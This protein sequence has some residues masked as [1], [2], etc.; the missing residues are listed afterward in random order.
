[1]RNRTVTVL[2]ATVLGLVA[3]SVLAADPSVIA[4][5]NLSSAGAAKVLAAA[6]L[7]ANRHGWA[8]SI[9]IVDAAGHLLAFQRTDGAPMGT[10]DVARRKAESSIKFKAPTEFLQKMV[11]QGGPAML[12]L[13]DYVAVVGGYPISVNG[14][15]VG[16]IGVSGGMA[17]EDEVIAK[18]GLAALAGGG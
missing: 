5:P 15:V 8:S 16:A 2:T 1:M 4:L 9:A 7:E 13:G 14:E 10:I 3:G 18:A 6:L 12:T 17:G 11:G